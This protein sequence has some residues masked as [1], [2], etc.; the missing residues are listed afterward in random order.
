MVSYTCLIL[1]GRGI[2]TEYLGADVGYAITLALA[3]GTTIALLSGGT[4]ATPLPHM[5]G[6]L[7]CGPITSESSLAEDPEA[8]S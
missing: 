5:W 8:G 4:T 1:P 6:L 2:A 3:T 7:S